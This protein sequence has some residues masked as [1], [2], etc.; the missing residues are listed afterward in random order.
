MMPAPG[1]SHER[2][3]VTGPVWHGR[4]VGGERGGDGGDGGEGAGD[5]VVRRR[6][7]EAD[8]EL[9]ALSL[10]DEGATAVELRPGP[11]GTV[12][13]VA[14]YP[15][16]EAARTVAAR[17]GL[18]VE[19]VDGSW[20]DAWKAYAK[21]VEVGETLVVA[22]AWVPLASGQTVL[23]IDPGPCFGSGSHPSTRLL[24]GLLAADPPAGLSVLDVGAGSGI[25]SV[26]AALLGAARVVAVD[27]DPASPP[28]VEANA[29]RNGV[30][31]EASTTPIEDVAGAFDLVLV[32][33]TAGVHAELAASATVHARPGGRLYL[34]GLL[35]G[36]WQHV[37]AC[38]DGCD[39]AELPQ[40]DGWVGAVLGKRPVRPSRLADIEAQ[41]AVERAAGSRFLAVG[42]P[43][44]AADEPMPADALASYADA[45]RSWVA[46][47]G[48]GHV[49]GFVVVDLLDD[50]AHIEEVSVEPAHQGR[51]LGRALIAE[52]ERW[53]RSQDLDAVTLT[54]FADVPWNRPL[55]EH[56]GF[57]TLA[58]DELTPGLRHRRREET[59]RGL[60]PAR[61]VCMRKPL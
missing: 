24:L 36:Q 6:V 9:A 47:D 33:V 22:P 34:A 14:S 60:D 41:R 17:L 57:R 45:G 42:M 39:V 50:C 53:A 49:V 23:Q 16:A 7:A 13:L 20:R 51:R 40:L 55:Y 15:T 56:L 38:Y 59:N 52:V 3:V 61:R 58:E 21:P 2:F 30:T 28:V 43:E 32:N 54:T 37:S 18:E 11:A 27:V 10:W 25:L 12:D 44:I 48:D 29:A 26:A 5:V 1:A 35:P 8:A 19:T 31:V 46:T 4:G